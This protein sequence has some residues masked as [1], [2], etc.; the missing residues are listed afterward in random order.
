M[1]GKSKT[2]VQVGGRSSQAKWNMLQ[3]RKS[4]SNLQNKNLEQSVAGQGVD[5]LRGVPIV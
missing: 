3:R 2:D 4:T 1:D 5:S